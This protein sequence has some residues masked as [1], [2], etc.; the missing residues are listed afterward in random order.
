MKNYTKDG[1]V[2]MKLRKVMNKSLTYLA[3]TTFGV[4]SLVIPLLAV[5]QTVYADEEETTTE[6]KEESSTVRGNINQT[7]GLKTQYSAM[8]KYDLSTQFA[9]T[10]NYLLG[11]PYETSDYSKL[12]TGI[13]GKNNTAFG[14]SMGDQL[15]SKP[16]I[17][18]TLDAINSEIEADTS[19]IDMAESLEKAES[20]LGIE[21]VKLVNKITDAIVDDVATAFTS[22]NSMKLESRVTNRSILRTISSSKN[23]SIN[24]GYVKNAL[25]I[26]LS[27]YIY[28]ELNAGFDSNLEGREDLDATVRRRVETILGYNKVNTIF[29]E[30]TKEGSFSY[31]KNPVYLTYPLDE[32][33]YSTLSKDTKDKK[34]YMYKNVF[35]HL[36]SPTGQYKPL[37]NGYPMWNAGVW[38]NNFKSNGNFTYKTVNGGNY[39]PNINTS[40]VAKD[41]KVAKIARVDG[42][43][44]INN[45]L[46]RLYAFE[47]YSSTAK[48]KESSAY[49]KSVKEKLKNINFKA[50]AD[51]YQ[52][53]KSSFD[54]S[55]NLVAY[56]PLQVSN[57]NT[58]K[59]LNPSDYKKELA[60]QND[61]LTKDT[62]DADVPINDMNNNARALQLKD[63]SVATNIGDSS[64]L[65]LGKNE[66]TR[67][68]PIL[69]S[70]DEGATLKS[71]RSLR[72]YMGVKYVSGK[73]TKLGKQELLTISDTD[74]IS[75]SSAMFKAFTAAGFSSGK[76]DNIV[77]IGIDNYGN[78]IATETGDIV[79]PYW[80]N[81]LFNDG[82]NNSLIS[83]NNAYK[84]NSGDEYLSNVLRNTSLYDISKVKSRAIKNIDGSKFKN[85]KTVKDSINSLPNTEQG[86][87]DIIKGKDNNLKS[88]L[89]MAITLATS[90]DVEEHNKQFITAISNGAGFYVYPTQTGYLSQE[91]YEENVL[92]RWNAASL[93]QKLGYFI[94]YGIF[95]VIRITF[96]QGIANLYDS[97]VTWVGNIFYN[98]NVTNS[99]TWSDIIYAL[100]GFALAFLI[101]FSA[102]MALQVFRKVVTFKD[103]AKKF[104]FTIV[105][106]VIPAFGYNQITNWMINEPSKFVL[107]NAV[108]Q[109]LVINFLEDKQANPELSNEDQMVAY[110][111]LFGNNTGNT[112]YT[113][114]KF[115]LTFYTN[116]SKTGDNVQEL[117]ASESNGWFAKNDKTLNTLNNQYPKRKLVSVQASIFDLYVWST[118]KVYKETGSPGNLGDIVQA[119]IDAYGDNTFFYYLEDKYRADNTYEGLSQYSEYE[120]DMSDIYSEDA[121]KSGVFSDTTNT[122][123]DF[124]KITA[125]EL[126]YQLQKNSIQNNEA[127]LSKGLKSLTTLVKVFNID[128]NYTAKDSVN[129]DSVYIPTS[130]DLETFIRDL[131]MTNSSRQQAYGSTQANSFSDFTKAVYSKNTSSKYNLPQEVLQETLPKEDYFGVYETITKL[132][133]AQENSQQNIRYDNARKTAYK[134]NS[135]TLNTV[136]RKYSNIDK[137][138][139]GSTEDTATNSAIQMSVLL[140]LYFNLNKELGLKNFPTD[141]QPSSV[142]FDNELKMI[143]IPLNEYGF[144]S[145]TVNTIST[146]NLMQYLAMRENPLVLTVVMI[147]I[148]MLMLF[149][150]FYWLVFYVLMMIIV[151]FKFFKEYVFASNYDNKSWLGML[152]IYGTLGLVRLG[153]ACLWWAG[154]SLLNSTVAIYGGLTYNAP[155]LHSLVIIFYLFFVAK[156]VVL[157]M[158]KGVLDDKENLGANYFASKMDSL[159]G[160]ISMGRMKGARDVPRSRG[161]RANKLRNGHKPN[162]LSRLTRRVRGRKGAS[163]SGGS[164]GSGAEVS[165]LKQK[166]M[167][168]TTAGIAKTRSIVNEKLGRTANA[169][170]TQQEK[171]NNQSMGMRK[172]TLNVLDKVQNTVRRGIHNNAMQRDINFG[173]IVNTANTAAGLGTTMLELSNLPQT[174]LADKGTEIVQ[175]LASQG[176]IARLGTKMVD[177]QE[178]K[179]LNIDTSALDMDNTYDRMTSVLG[180]QTYLKEEMTK[181]ARQ[182]VSGDVKDLESFESNSPM[183]SKVSDGSFI[184]NSTFD[185]GI[186]FNTMKSV[187][188][189]RTLDVNGEDDTVT[190]LRNKYNFEKVSWVNDNGVEVINDSKYRLIPKGNKELSKEE[191]AQDMAKFRSIDNAV[192]LRQNKQLAQPELMT[193]FTY[194]HLDFT[195][196]ELPMVEEFVK[197]SHGVHLVDGNKLVYDPT[198]SSSVKEVKKFTSALDSRNSESYKSMQKVESSLGAYGLRGAGHG[199]LQT[200]V[201]NSKDNAYDID[202]VFGHNYSAKNSYVV[203][204]DKD[205]DENSRKLHSSLVT[206]SASAK[207]F[208][209]DN[210][211]RKAIEVKDSNRQAMKSSVDKI[212]MSDT[213]KIGDSLNFIESNDR[214]MASS[215]MFKS[216]RN[217]YNKLQNDLKLGNITQ[218]KY[219]NLMPL[220]A[221]QTSEILESTALIEGFVKDIDFND[222]KQKGIQVMSDKS[223]QSNIEGVIKAKETI[224][225]KLQLDDIKDVDKNN[226]NSEYV[227]RAT[228]LFGANGSVEANALNNTITLKTDN[229][230]DIKGKNLNSMF[231]NNKYNQVLATQVSNDSPL[232]DKLLSKYVPEKT[233][234]TS[235]DNAS[236]SVEKVTPT[237]DSVLES[238]MK[239]TRNTQLVSPKPK[240]DVKKNFAKKSKETK[241]LMSSLENTM[242]EAYKNNTITEE[243]IQKHTSL[244]AEL[245]RLERAKSQDEF[246]EN[247]AQLIEN[248]NGLEILQKSIKDFSNTLDA[249]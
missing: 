9:I 160:K 176:T 236:G 93:I 133:S 16:D 140:E 44:N 216:I 248:A 229:E 52:A 40:Y 172:N 102:Y 82:L 119:D 144:Q 75:T 57:D 3:L 56:T 154:Y 41:G 17:G 129:G 5:P 91:E 110:N 138:I 163:G 230:L 150:A 164:G 206:S 186:D 191:V 94:D 107:D 213:P 220:Y 47:P 60:K 231:M 241:S 105:A 232:V 178:I 21:T 116:T 228:T 59:N 108:K 215:P 217:D 207:L 159:K 45:Q 147:A 20:K 65:M 26:S 167:S 243:D 38:D 127:N 95:E 185:H 53:S 193:D 101:V 100:A 25:K 239:D 226:I 104:L 136:A 196:E 19:Q 214:L 58:A 36:T 73:P 15:L 247:D 14:T 170:L 74:Y 125:S 13:S 244:Q 96:A 79:I 209:S 49:S 92:T 199:V 194:A 106:L 225:T 240:K 222:Y 238:N 37:E 245:Q 233:V 76:K 39:N 234:E 153:L 242:K 246:L 111:E 148:F 156:L 84:L 208:E 166:L 63:I 70:E 224:Q 12:Y 161:S 162:A 86:V 173:D 155:F 121:I 124:G 80:Q 64:K 48:P 71:K 126:F 118:Y 32:K 181:G 139:G 43:P 114:K 2:F 46:N 179:T 235:I 90:K 190:E 30:Q 120:I 211:F 34:N 78:L 109:G 55:G 180:L 197:K 187:F 98:E 134:V 29:G 219:D 175:H 128:N 123:A 99:G 50:Y 27:H 227:E 202:R 200:G 88:V 221:M 68:Y 87:V 168:G 83:A 158:V 4:S 62:A 149:W 8:A 112:D 22:N 122:N 141:Y 210:D 61:V 171:L 130:S 198:V 204:M 218:E 152:Y 182:F 177:G 137:L 143:F 18:K 174:L 184:M 188:E 10:Y 28:K 195:E 192:R 212:F 113:N 189:D 77:A 142:S 85:K 72:Q 33:S 24:N 89:A 54:F 146:K 183:F 23:T 117:K 69:K 237:V 249:K 7:T 223:K 67:G 131:S 42:N 31:E 205:S 132:M 145:K 169:N 203:A 151:V 135:Y 66:K 103:F 201:L 81:G 35:L 97:I 1:G 165:S 51:E 6:D 11:N 157:P 115:V